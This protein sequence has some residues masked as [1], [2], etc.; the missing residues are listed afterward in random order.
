MSDPLLPLFGALSVEQAAWVR[1]ID[2]A[3][4]TALLVAFGSAARTLGRAAV[5]VS[6]RGTWPTD[7][8]AR[9]LLLLRAVHEAA[10]DLTDELYDRGDNG[11]RQAVLR[12]LPL[13]PHPAAYVD[14][15]VNACRTSVQTIFDAIACENPFP[16]RYFPELS[17][18][19]MVLKAMFNGVALARI[20]GLAARVTPELTRMAEGYASER[21]AAGRTVPSDITL[22]N[23]RGQP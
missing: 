13:L 8:V 1:G 10:R 2:V 20:A 12:A 11:E 15:A 14:L 19:Q 16:T 22:L 17:F 7:E 18:N 5:P 3:D 4:R 9:A 23:V 6:G 21:R